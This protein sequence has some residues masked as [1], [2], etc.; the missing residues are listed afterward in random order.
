MFVAAEIASSVTQ[1]LARVTGEM[2]QRV[3]S[4][5]PRAKVTW[6]PPE[7]M[8]LTVLFI[9]EVDDDRAAAI[10][11]AL[12]PPLR[13]A[14]FDLTVTGIGTFPARGT[15]RVIWAGVGNGREALIGVER[16]ISA[17][18]HQVGAPRFNPHLTLARVRD[19]AGL[20]TR[21]LLAGATST[22][23]GTARVEAITL[24][25]SRLSP[26]GPTYV[27]LQSTRLRSRVAT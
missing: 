16:E 26:K 18:L 10:R 6:I 5:A 20:R 14:A 23:Y 19:A 25:E 13:V 15:P 12:T 22:A 1:E 4:L 9:G 7:R 24:F 2:R 21:D 11:E 27:P 8:H 3:E 17:R